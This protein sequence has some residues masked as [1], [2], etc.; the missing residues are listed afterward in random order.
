MAILGP[1]PAGAPEQAFLYDKSYE[2]WPFWAPGR[3]GPTCRENCHFTRVLEGHSGD[4][5]VKYGVLA[6]TAILRRF[7]RVLE[8]HSVVNHVKHGVLA[9]IDEICNFTTVLEG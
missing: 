3:P 5:H 6:K 7:W 1:R 9:N 8:E 4:N 2:T